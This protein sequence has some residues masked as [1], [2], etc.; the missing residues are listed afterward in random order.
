MDIKGYVDAGPD[1][2]LQLLQGFFRTWATSTETARQ[3]FRRDFEYTEGN[4]KQWNAAARQE[5]LKSGRPVNEINQILPQVEFVAG[6]QRD[7]EIDFKLLP[8]GYSDVRL[9]E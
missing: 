8:R 9:A 3:K 6:M 5:V 4:G 7:M 2:S 1:S